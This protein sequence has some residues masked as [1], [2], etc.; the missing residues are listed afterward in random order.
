MSN[1]SDFLNDVH[2]QRKYQDANDGD[3]NK[4]FALN[5][6]EALAGAVQSDLETLSNN[7][8]PKLATAP[9]VISD[10]KEQEK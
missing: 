5:W 2:Q 4:R 9:D 1:I 7:K 8:S 10:E 6:I 3:Y